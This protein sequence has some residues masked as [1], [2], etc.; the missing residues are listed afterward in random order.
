MEKDSNGGDCRIQAKFPFRHSLPIQIRFNDIDS[1]GHVNNTVY[2][3]YFDLGKT[4]YFNQ[5]ATNPPVDGRATLVAANVNCDFIEPTRIDEKITVSTQVESI[6]HK[7]FK[8]LHA[9]ENTETGKIKCLCAAIMVVVDITTGDTRPVPAEW[10]AAI[11]AH[12]GRSM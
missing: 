4:S 3:S 6:G 7:S 1:L 8:M 10:R 11:A 12:E 2:F 9:I 5:V